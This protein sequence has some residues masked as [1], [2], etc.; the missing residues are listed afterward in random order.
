MSF[1]WV[2]YYKEFAEK[3]LQYQE[4]RAD[5]CRLIYDH[6]D[7]L[8]INYLH[9]EGGKDDKF[10]DIDP[11]TTFGLFNR[12]ISMKNRASSAALFKR[13]LN[14]SADVPSDFDGV[15]ILNNQKSHFFGFRPDRKPGDIEN[16]WRLFVKVV[17]KEDFENEYNALLG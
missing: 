3:L 4:N 14:I 6:E 1:T 7:E 9:D 11:F 13:L 10:T 17:K 15:P 8:L 5:L 16:L 12:G 2:P